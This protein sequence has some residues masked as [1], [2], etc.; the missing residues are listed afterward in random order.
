[1]A[2]LNFHC[3]ERLTLDANRHGYFDDYDFRS[4]GRTVEVTIDD[5]PEDKIEQL[6]DLLERYGIDY[7]ENT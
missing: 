6:K 5:E 1:M 7:E 2:E 4:W 3:T